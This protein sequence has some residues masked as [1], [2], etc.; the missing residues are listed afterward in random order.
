MNCYGGHGG[1]HR[2]GGHWAVV[3]VLVVA[4]EWF[5]IVFNIIFPIFFVFVFVTVAGMVGTIVNLNRSRR[6]D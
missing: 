6:C 5:V 1:H 4:G 3:G 2:P